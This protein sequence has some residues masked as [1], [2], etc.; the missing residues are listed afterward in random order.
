MAKIGQII[1][2]P[3]SGERLVVYQTAASTQGQLFSFELI[4]AAG[5]HVPGSHV[6]PLQEERFTVLE[7]RMRFR[8][9]LRTVVAM[10][11]QTVAVPPGTVHRFENAAHGSVARAVVEV[12]PALRM[13]ELFETIADL[14]RE[15][16]TL[17]N[18]M[19]RPLDFALFLREFRN[20]I[21]VPLLPDWV[22]RAGSAPLIKAAERHGLDARYSRRR[23]LAA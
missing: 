2:N 5:G 10:E 9:G 1:D 18:G 11:G 12:R 21:R 7:G 19:P 6:H 15:R 22:V 16:R 23:R 13:E 14:A 17:A 20:E 8:R 3:A 4:L